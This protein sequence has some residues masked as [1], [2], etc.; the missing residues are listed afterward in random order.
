MF[1]ALKNKKI[2]K[3][4]KNGCIFIRYISVKTSLIDTSDEYSYKLK[5]GNLIS[6]KL[7]TVNNNYINYKCF[8]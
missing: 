8:E 1:C 3:F 7:E 6:I 5:S 4:A 2:A